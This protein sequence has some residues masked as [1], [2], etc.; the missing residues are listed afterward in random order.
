MPLYLTIL[1]GVTPA[2]ARPIL[3]IRDDE[4]LATV[5][6]MIAARLAGVPTETLVSPGPQ[7]APQPEVPGA[8]E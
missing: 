3:A 8:T 4:I 2:K 5:R 7:E 1:E 6:A